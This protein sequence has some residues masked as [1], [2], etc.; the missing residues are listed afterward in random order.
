[1]GLYLAFASLYLA[2]ASLYL[3]FVIEALGLYLTGNPLSEYSDE[4]SR[5]ELMELA[6]LKEAGGA[7]GLVKVAG[8]VT[9]MRQTKIKSGPNAGR[10]MG[11][12]VLEDLSTTLPIAV[13]AAKLQQFG[14]L[15]EDEAVVVVQGTVRERGSDLEMSADEIIAV[16]READRVLSVDLRVPSALSSQ[17]LFELRDLLIEHP[18]ETPVRLSYRLPD[19][20]VHIAPRADL[21]I[22]L[23]LQLTSSLEEMLGAGSVRER[24]PA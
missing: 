14:H 2:F 15:L 1:M 4:L 16:H 20:T 12:F 17:Q 6:A 23:D 11:R 18:G 22:D 7:E 9:Q 10:F 21:C 3:A 24:R 19:R 13:F 5:F 8:L